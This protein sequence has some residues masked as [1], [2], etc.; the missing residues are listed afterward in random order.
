MTASRLTLINKL[1]RVMMNRKVIGP[2]IVVSVWVLFFL[3][4]SVRAQMEILPLQVDHAIFRA[5]GNE[6]FLEIYLAFPQDRFLYQV[7]DTLQYSTFEIFYYVYQGEEVIQE[8]TKEFENVLKA[9][10]LI[11]E[12]RQFLDA[13]IFK[14]PAGSYKVLVRVEDK[15]SGRFGEYIFETTIPQFSGTELQL[16]DIELC[17]RIFK[18]QTRTVFSKNQLT[19]IPNPGCVY[20]IQLPV[21][22]YYAEV[23]N[24]TYSPSQETFYETQLLITNKDGEVIRE[25]PPRQHRTPGTSAVI[26]G[27][28]NVLAL[29][30]GTYFLK[31]R[32]SDLASGKSTV[33]MKRF[34]LYK[35]VKQQEPVVAVNSQKRDDLLRSYYARLTEE[36]LDREFEMSKYIA[37]KDEIDIYKTLNEEGKRTFLVAFWARRDPNPRTPQNEF[38]NDYFDRLNFANAQ[39]SSNRKEGWQTD[40]GRVLLLYGRPSEI[41][42]HIM[43]VNQKPYEIWY[44]NDLEGGV[45]F[46]FADIEGFGEFQLLHSTYSKEIHQPGW[47]SLVSPL[48]RE[49]ENDEEIYMDYPR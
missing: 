9:G 36:E 8:H 46:V 13:Q 16:S 39:W 40:R 49:G 23:Y 6:A 47:K 25:Y 22:F 2:A 32:V 41:E 5:E 43:R 34:V 11:P 44:Y 29:K 42:R 26:A 15:R 17:S 12:G 1:L 27:G 21:V 24:L 45:S 7:K 35:P 4:P 31:I 10:Q 30:P 33:K 28:R 20:G 19:L 37:T 18:N 3:S 14:L 38:R 48:K